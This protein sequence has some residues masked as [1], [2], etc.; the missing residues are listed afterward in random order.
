MRGVEDAQFQSAIIG[1][2]EEIVLS[3]PFINKGESGVFLSIDYALHQLSG[4]RVHGQCGLNLVQIDHSQT[5]PP[6]CPHGGLESL[7]GKQR[8]WASREGYIL[9]EPLEDS[10]DLV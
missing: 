9:C 10:L 6:P 7:G 8:C 1:N 2:V 5:Y 4:K 3:S